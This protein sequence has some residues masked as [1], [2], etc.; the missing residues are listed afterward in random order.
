MEKYSKECMYFSIILIQIVLDKH[1][2]LT[3]QCISRC[4]PAFFETWSFLKNILCEMFHPKD[5][6]LKEGQ[7]GRRGGGENVR[8][9]VSN[10]IYDDKLSEHSTQWLLGCSQPGSLVRCLPA[11]GI[12]AFTIFFA[13]IDSSPQ[14]P[15]GWCCKKSNNKISGGRGTTPA[16]NVKSGGWR[17]IFQTA[18]GESL[19]RKG[20]AECARKGEMSHYLRF[21]S[22]KDW[23][24]SMHM[25]SE[26]WTC[27]LAKSLLIVAP[28]SPD[29]CLKSILKRD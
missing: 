6:C 12:G 9:S 13:V 3:A 11:W 23:Q 24:P 4:V 26:C 7:Q 15:D 25:S 21:T 18:G 29:L 28:V 14:L 27:W 10:L 22:S 2:Y 20:R 16:V 5:H 1:V 17:F 19:K 8:V